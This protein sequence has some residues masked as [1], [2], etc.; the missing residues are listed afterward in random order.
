M[1]AEVVK[2]GPHI[3]A[4]NAAAII[5]SNTTDLT[6]PTRWIIVGT[7]GNV[8]LDMV[9]GQTSVVIPLP[10]GVWPIPAKRVRATSTT[11]LNLVALW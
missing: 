8:E 7:A 10:A 4:E 5:P 1:S 3:P 6:A 2:Y 11:A 9:G